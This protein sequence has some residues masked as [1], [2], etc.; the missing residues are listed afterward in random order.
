MTLLTDAQVLDGLA[1]LPGWH[2]V[3][4]TI[5]KTAKFESFAEA[6]SFVVRL[7][8]EAEQADHHPDLALHYRELTISYWTHTAGGVTQKDL[9]G[10]AM[11]EKLLA[12]R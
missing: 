3:Q 7:A 8:F 9:D 10:A 2:R 12:P 1:R 5:A 6:V 4:N 11:I